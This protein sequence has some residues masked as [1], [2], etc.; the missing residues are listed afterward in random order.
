MTAVSLNGYDRGMSALEPIDRY[1]DRHALV[2]P[3]A[4][5][6]LAPVAG[7]KL[8]VVIPALAER[9]RLGG[10]LDSLSVGSAR[11]SEAE[12]IVV[13]N[14]P[15]DADPDTSANNQA[16]LV[17]LGAR[18]AG[19][20]SLQVLDRASP[21]SALQTQAAGV[22]LAR[23]IG[24]DLA[25]SRL[26][27][28]GQPDRAAIACLDADSPV[29]PGYVD[30]LLAAF[31][32]AEPPVG[33]VCACAHPIPEDPLLG[34]AILAYE[35]WMR[36]FEL[37]LRLAG[38]PFSYPTIG[39]C[40][41]A[42]AAGYALADGMP[43]RPA[44]EDFHFAQKLIKV[45]GRAGLQRLTGALVL[46]AARRS[47]RVPFGT[48]RAM[49]RCADEGLDA[50]RRV[51]PPQAFFDLQRWFASFEPGFADP[52]ALRRATSPDLA[53][54]LDAERAWGALERIRDN[55]PDA[56]HFGLAVHH[57]FDGLKC[58]RFVHALERQRGRVWAF[59]AL[60]QVLAALGLAG[61]FADLAPPQPPDPP[62]ELLQAWLERLRALD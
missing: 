4:Q 38:S 53:A 54:F 45:A 50:F 20:L 10:V 3:E 40:L 35:T 57:W 41:V 44:G 34:P 48:G 36:Y 31:D 61:R 58:V 21:G 25:L 6:L 15:E 52:V 26:A 9:A 37:G 22:G 55:Q 49:L 32:R 5:R 51:E 56:T 19:S 46:P 24:M 16:S 18:P 62:R 2:P 33:G 43:E 47:A 42:S 30:A 17:E 14:Q 7:L 11:L 8:C 1:L 23:R 59:D 29:A 13:V 27:R 12:V 60:A 39:S 28:A